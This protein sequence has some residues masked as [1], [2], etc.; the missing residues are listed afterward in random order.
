[1]AIID[2]RTGPLGQRLAKHLLRRATYNITKDRVDYF[3]GLTAQQALSELTILPDP[4]L[5][6][7]IDHETGQPWINSGVEP[8]SSNFR[9]YGYVKGWWVDEARRDTGLGHKLMF[10]LHS[11]FVVNAQILNS[12]FNYDYYKLMRHY[13]FGSFKEL[14]VKISVDNMMLDFLDGRYSNKYNPNEN[15]GR[16][17]LELFTI[18]K[19]DQTGP[20][21]YTNYTELDVQEAARLF[22]GWRVNDRLNID[23]DTGLPTGY[24]DLNRHDVDDKTFSYRFQNQTVVGRNTEQGMYDEISDFVDIIF[25]QAETAKFICRKLYRYFVSSEI[26]ATIETEII[27]PLAVTFRTNYN[28]SEV[29]TKLLTSKHFYGEDDSGN[30]ANNI[31][32]GLIKNPLQSLLQTLTYFNVDVPDP[33]NDSEMH[34]ETFYRHSVLYDLFELAGLTLFEPSSVA[35][36]EP[37]YQAPNYNRGW[38]NSSVIISRYKLPE[39]LLTGDRVLS[40]GELGVQLNFVEWVENHISNPSD[41]EVLIAEI[42]DYLF[43]ENADAERKAYFLNTVLLDNIP[44]AEWSS[45]W[46]DYIGNNNIDAVQTPLNRLFTGILYSQEFQLS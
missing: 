7:P 11:N 21:D 2:P 9:L 34:Y 31:I 27:E 32:G 35:G 14:S 1:M 17:F 24:P 45:A 46:A 33:I 6:E 29:V 12:S 39:M 23:P 8:I 28:M 30:S 25:G 36:Y 3:A 22:T 18:G 43:V 10:F 42:T 19:G 44:M 5:E 13:C 16:E 26:D 38:F 20:D 15:Y 40:Y 4:Y 37:F 41:P